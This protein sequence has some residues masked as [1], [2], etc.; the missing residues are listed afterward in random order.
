VQRYQPFNV[1]FHLQVLQSF[2]SALAADVFESLAIMEHRTH[3][4]SHG[5]NNMYGRPGH[6]RKFWFLYRRNMLASNQPAAAANAASMLTPP[7]VTRS[8]PRTAVAQ[9]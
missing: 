6:A 3:L 1:H 8:S 2:A 4:Q 9:Q 5:Y 7:C